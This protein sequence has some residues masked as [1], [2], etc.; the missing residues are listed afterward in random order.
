MSWQQIGSD[1]PGDTSGDKLG[2]DVAINGD[3]TIAAFSAQ[4]GDAGGTDSGEVKVMK[5]ENGS[6]SQLGSSIPGENAGDRLWRC[7]LDNT[8]HRIVVGE[9]LNDGTA[10]AA[11]GSIKVYDYNSGTDSWSIVGS[12]INGEGQ[13]GFDVS[14]NSDGSRIVIGARY[15]DD[16]GGSNADKGYVEVYEYSSGSWSLVGSRIAGPVNRSAFGSAVDISS[17]GNR[18]IVGAATTDAD[19][20]AG[21]DR[22]G[23]IFM[24]EYSDGSWTQMGSTIFGGTN[25][26]QFG[27][28]VAMSDDGTR[29]FAGARKGSYGQAYEWNSGTSSWSQLG[30]DLTVTTSNLLYVDMSGTG[31]VVVLG[32]WEKTSSTG[33]VLVYKYE[34]SS[35]S[36]VSSAITGQNTGDKFGSSVAI[37]RQ[38]DYIAVGAIANDDASSDAGEGYIYYNSSLSSNSSDVSTSN[39]SNVGDSATFK[40]EVVD[41]LNSIS[42]VSISSSDV[43]A[44]ATRVSTQS[45]VDY[46]ITV[47][48]SNV[49]LSD[50]NTS[51]QDSLKS[52]IKS[53]YATD[54]SIAETRITVTLSAG[55]INAEIQIAEAPAESSG[56]GG[57]FKVTGSGF[58]VVSNTGF[59]LVR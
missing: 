1:I 8:G 58:F 16:G 19:G 12:E 52:V 22:N 2:S 48:I 26:D 55:S 11:N 17:D 3:G 51:Q 53:R 24:Y 20:Q 7:K 57:F 47:T 40:N 49:N 43:S 36:L 32:D 18:I 59:L 38:G 33:E 28:S 45:G 10:S 14:I 6:W 5:Y 27:Y 9:Y 37:N 54:L 46:E 13:S 30:S 50:L 21:D 15:W 34:S 23:G 35:W 56:G 4:Y 31:D 41:D 25:Q 29:V 42:G 44:G 39:V